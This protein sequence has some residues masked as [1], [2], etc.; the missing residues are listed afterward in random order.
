MQARPIDA[1]LAAILESIYDVERDALSWISGILE[2]LN[3]S[4]GDGVGL[5]G[6]VYAVT[7]TGRLQTNSLTC[8]DCHQAVLDRWRIVGRNPGGRGLAVVVNRRRRGSPS[9]EQR[10]TLTRIAKHF[11]AAHRLRE[12]LVHAPIEAFSD[13]RSSARHAVMDERERALSPR[14]RQVLTLAVRGHRNKQIAFELGIGHS[15]VRVLLTRA[16]KKLD[17]RSHHELLRRFEALETPQPSTVPTR[18]Q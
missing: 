17:V 1:E 10:A 8:L 16:A 7:S 4:I 13:A 15:T 14:E 11:A 12:R 6:F 3:A 2:R 9:S 5:F 18:S